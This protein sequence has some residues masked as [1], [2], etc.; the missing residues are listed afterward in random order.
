MNSPSDDL[1]I[2]QDTT[3]PQPTLDRVQTW[4]PSRPRFR[5]LW[6]LGLLLTAA[7]CLLTLTMTPPVWVDE[8]HIVEYGRLFL[9]PQ[10]SWS[11]HW[12]DGHTTIPWYFVG[13]LLQELATRA[14]M[15]SCAGT[16]LVSLAGALIASSMFVRWL[17]LRRTTPAAALLLGLL[18]LFDPNFAAAYRGGRLDGWTLSLAFSALCLIIAPRARIATMIGAGALLALAFFVWPSVT[19]LFPLVALELWRTRPLANEPRWKEWAAVIAGGSLMFALLLTIA[20]LQIGDLW[21]HITRQLFRAQMSPRPAPLEV[22]TKLRYLINL[23]FVQDPWNLPLLIACWGTS[24]SRSTLLAA[25]LPATLMIGTIVYGNRVIY[26]LPYLAV[27]YAEALSDR[28]TLQGLRARV[29]W[30]ALALGVLVGGGVSLVLRSG[31]AWLARAARDERLLQV[32]TGTIPRD[33]RVCLDSFEFYFVGRSNGWRM[34]TAT[35]GTLPQCEYMISNSPLVRPTL[36]PALG[37]A[38]FEPAATLLL[39]RA[40]SIPVYGARGYGPYLVFR[41]RAR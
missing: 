22:L 39:D 25:L 26:L 37:E 7:F 3:S 11:L 4:Q 5:A 14:S 24:A 41:R 29:A 35:P 17:L 36:Q 10:S 31:N 12:H 40:E 16:R 8:G 21:H 18:V 1:P 20:A 6:T 32:A 23:L 2:A 28:T 13:A 34:Y 9:D 15:P 30:G 38:G 19:F 33:A 27:F